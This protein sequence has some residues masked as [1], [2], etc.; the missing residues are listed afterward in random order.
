M[1]DRTIQKMLTA[2]L[3]ANDQMHWAGSYAHGL[4]KEGDPY[5]VLFPAADHLEFQIC[6]VYPEHYKKLPEFIITDTPSH[7][8][9]SKSSPKKNDAIKCPLFCVLTYPGKETNMG[10]ETRFSDVLFVSK[11]KPAGTDKSAPAGPKP[12]APTQPPAPRPNGP[13]QPKPAPVAS[14][15]TAS[16]T[17]FCPMC[18][19]YPVSKPGEVCENCERNLNADAP[20]LQNPHPPRPWNPA[21]L[22][23]Y[24]SIR[25]GELA[26][27]KPIS[28]DQRKLIGPVID[29]IFAGPHALQRRR[30]ILAYLFQKED[31]H[32]L[33]NGQAIAC[34]RWLA[35]SA[36]SG[37]AY[38]AAAH[39]VD[40]INGIATLF[41]VS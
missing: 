40:E 30:L 37:G 39:A 2:I 33:T 13:S 29:A 26:T 38:Q 12:A 32:L 27:E 23:K 21:Y 25:A 8:R 41:K 15:P 9:P 20:T 3:Q 28:E 6:R 19:V 36:D 31:P 5:L 1:E 17:H 34:L 7:V 11:S 35:P 24:L 10:P 4:T 16:K 22:R 18:E 14:P